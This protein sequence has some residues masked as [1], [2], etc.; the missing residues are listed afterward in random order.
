MTK[1]FSGIIVLSITLL[2]ASCTTGIVDFDALFDEL[3]TSMV[4]EGDTLETITQDVSFLTRSALLTRATITWETDRPDVILSDGTVIRPELEPV[5]VTVT[6]TIRVGLE[7]RTRTY[8]LTVLP[9]AVFS[10]SI[11]VD[12][13]VTVVDVPYGSPVP[14]PEVDVTEAFEFVG[15]VIEGTGDMYVPLDPVT[16]DLTLI[17]S[18][19]DRTYDV[20]FDSVGGT[21]VPG[22]EDVIHST[23]LEDLPVPE[24]DGYMFV[25]WIFIDQWGNEQLLVEG[26]T[27]INHDIHAQARWVKR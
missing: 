26:L 21:A 20:T 27:I 7:A 2:L 5:T 16:S 11:D 24:K 9:T 6:L 22:L 13:E 1:L 19:I 4:A 12:G 10:V 3:S 15:W 18:I 14:L 8:V 17:A 25:G 23:T